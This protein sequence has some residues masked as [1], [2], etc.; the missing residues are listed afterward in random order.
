MLERMFEK[1]MQQIRNEEKVEVSEE[2]KEEEENLN[3]DE[4]KIVNA[5]QVDKV[6]NLLIK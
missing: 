6:W 3:D 2:T 5:Y 4:K 1:R